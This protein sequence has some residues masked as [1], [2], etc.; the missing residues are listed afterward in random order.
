MA[1][2]FHILHVE[3]DDLD[4]LNVQRFLRSTNNV[5]GITVAHDAV[6]ALEML[7][8]GQLPLRSLVILLDIRL[9]RMSGLEFMRE[10]RADPLLRRLPVVVFST[11]D[12][13]RDMDTAYE[14]NAA[15][16]L[17]KPFS[18]ERFQHCMDAFAHYWASAELL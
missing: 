8:S 13:E 2:K 1:E 17:V 7:R 15:G 3:D 14:L 11:S 5:G 12:D 4:A 10:L 6:E 16:Y 9:P 18:P